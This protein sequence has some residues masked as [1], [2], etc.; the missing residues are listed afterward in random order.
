MKVYCE[1]LSL[2]HVISVNV[3]KNPNVLFQGL[4]TKVIALDADGAGQVD[5]LCQAAGEYRLFSQGLD[6]SGGE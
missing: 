5:F 1:R 4:D 2:S 3:W 6:S